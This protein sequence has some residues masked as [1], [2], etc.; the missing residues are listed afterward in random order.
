MALGREQSVSD[1]GVT[2]E[3]IFTSAPRR[4]AVIEAF[5]SGSAMI[6]HDHGTWSVNIT[7][8]VP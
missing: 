5:G 1:A 3:T 4:T 6:L 7:D 2:E 8:Q